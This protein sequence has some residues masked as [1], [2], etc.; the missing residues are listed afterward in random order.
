MCEEACVHPSP[1][2]ARFFSH[3]QACVGFMC[4]CLANYFSSSSDFLM[5]R[6]ILVTPPPIPFTRLRGVLAVLLQKWSGR[7]YMPCRHPLVA[8]GISNGAFCILKVSWPV[9]RSTVDRFDIRRLTTIKVT[10]YLY[11]IAYVPVILRATC[12][13]A[14]ATTVH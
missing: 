2:T 4:D 7:P 11:A 9:R 5:C 6:F 13:Y 1:E 14:L 8:I 12:K 10:L 3:H